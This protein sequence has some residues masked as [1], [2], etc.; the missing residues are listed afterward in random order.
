MYFFLCY[1]GTEFKKTEKLQEKVIRL[2]KFMANN[3]SVLNDKNELKILKLKDF[4]I[5]T[6]YKTYSLL[7]PE[8]TNTRIRDQK[9]PI[10]CK[11]Q[12]FKTEKY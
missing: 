9:V 4:I 7:R 12:D 11:K 2:I 1:Q 6:L 5:L 8:T 10:N 3:A